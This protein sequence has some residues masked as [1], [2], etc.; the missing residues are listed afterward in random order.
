MNFSSPRTSGLDPTYTIVSTLSLLVR[1]VYTAVNRRRSIHLFRLPLLVPC[2]VR[3]TRCQF[4]VAAW[5]TSTGVHSLDFV[6]PIIGHSN[7]LSKVAGNRVRYNVGNDI[8]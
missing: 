5:T 6:V 1:Y 4:P 8:G 2:H 7:R 3:T